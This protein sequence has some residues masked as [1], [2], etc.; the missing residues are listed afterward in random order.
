MKTAGTNRRL[1]TILTGLRTGSLVPNPAFQRRLVWSNRHKNAFLE[2]VLAGLPFPEIFIAAGT[3][4]TET[5]EGTELIVDGQQRITTLNQYFTASPDLKL[6]SI[7]AYVD[8]PENEKADFLEYEV[9][10]RDLG[11]L[12]ND[13]TRDLFYRINSTSYSLNAM[14]VNNARFD[15]ALKAYCDG[16]SEHGFFSD[17]NVF[18]AYDAKRMNDVRWILTLVATLLSTYF[19]RD[20][21]HERFLEIYNDE[22]PEAATL[23]ARLSNTFKAIDDMNFGRDSRIWQKSDLFTIVVEVDRSLRT[24]GFPGVK[25]AADRLAPF[26]DLVDR[27]ARGDETVRDRRP[28]EYFAA[29]RSGTNDRSSRIRRGRVISAVLEGKTA[30]IDAE[31]ERTLFDD[32]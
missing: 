28:N 2:T 27:V 5:G 21:E 18:S 11:A 13:Q 24:G 4:D 25:A 1:R 15:G 14:E 22:F 16:L 8:L 23:T 6:V 32:I 9:V 3:V 31:M 29:T 26:Y 10:V 30:T 17:H 7:P 19:N 20:S 12:T